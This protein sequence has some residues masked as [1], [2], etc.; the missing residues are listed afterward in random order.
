[1]LHNLGW[2]SLDSRRQDQRL[3]LFLLTGLRRLKRRTSSR[4]PTPVQGR[5]TASNSN[6]SRQIVIQ[7]GTLFFQPLF[8]AGTTF[9]LALRRLTV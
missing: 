4:Q 7:I 3:V 1:M 8:R 2:Q 9:H 6:T 5:I